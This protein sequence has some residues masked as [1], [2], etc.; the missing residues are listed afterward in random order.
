M[1]CNAGPGSPLLSRRLTE[2]QNDPSRGQTLSEFTFHSRKSPTL[3]LRRYL[4]DH[5]RLNRMHAC[6]VPSARLGDVLFIANPCDINDLRSCDSV[7]LLCRPVTLLNL[8]TV[9]DEKE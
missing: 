6:S 3:Q 2:P 1:V 4:V 7:V 5:I 8:L 9:G